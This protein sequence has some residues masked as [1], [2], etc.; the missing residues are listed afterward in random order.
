MKK[1]VLIVIIGFLLAGGLGVL[2][3]ARDSIDDCG[4]N[5]VQKIGFH[6]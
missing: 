5:N 6:E 3:Q 1:I 2:V 4:C